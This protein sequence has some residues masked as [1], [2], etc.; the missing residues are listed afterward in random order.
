MERKQLLRLFT[1][2]ALCLPL[3]QLSAQEWESRL[4]PYLWFAGIDGDVATL[5]G[6]PVVPVKLSASDALADN[7]TSFMG[8]YELRNPRHGLVIEAIYTDTRTEETLVEEIGLEMTSVSKNTVFSASYEHTVLDTG[9]T[10]LDLLAGLRYW[11]IDSALRFSGGLGVLES[12]R[13]S[14]DDDWIDPLVGIKGRSGLGDSNF[15]LA[16]WLIGGGFGVG[17]DAFYDGSLNLG[18]QWSKS[19]GTTLGY[20]E[21]NVDYDDDGFVYDV[22]QNG[23]SVGLTWSF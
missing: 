11:E 4:T 15:Y 17:S 8:I 3:T 12:R 10:R 7:E 21:F 22:R 23:W 20:R 16:Y 2:L 9:S 13:V 18:Y 5:P 1:G 14:N 6:F 19:I